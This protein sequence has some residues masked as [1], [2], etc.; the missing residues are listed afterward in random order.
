EA[1]DELTQVALDVTE[2]GEQSGVGEAERLGVADLDDVGS[3]V[4]RQR[5][6]VGVRDVVPG[7]LL[8]GEGPPFVLVLERLLEVVAGRLR[9]VSAHEPY[10]QI[11]GLRVC[12]RGSSATGAGAAGQC[13]GRHAGEREGTEL[14][15]HGGSFSWWFRGTG[16]PSGGMTGVRTPLVALT[17]P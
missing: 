10:R 15:V 3:V 1:A 7:L 14:L 11:A 16:D 5:G 6:G 2:I 4:G 12:R 17:G 8:D 13:D 9:R